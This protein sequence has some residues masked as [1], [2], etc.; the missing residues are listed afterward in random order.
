[1]ARPSLLGRYSLHLTV[2]P[3]QHSFQKGEYPHNPCGRLGDV[4]PNPWSWRASQGSVPVTGDRPAHPGC[5]NVPAGGLRTERGSSSEKGDAV[6]AA[7]A[8]QTR[9]GGRAATSR[10]RQRLWGP[11]T[12]TDSAGASVSRPRGP[13]VARVRC[14]AP[15][16]RCV[17]AAE[18]T[19]TLMRT[20]VLWS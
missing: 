1:M 20:M 18:G 9:L 5:S 13:R 17:T 6:T 11:E 10:A 7:E 12:G 16:V 2:Y 19:D 14:R 8:G 3:G 4:P 15:G